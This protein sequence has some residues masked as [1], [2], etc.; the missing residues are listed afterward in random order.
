[1]EISQPIAVTGLPDT[2]PEDIG[3]IATIAGTTVVSGTIEANETVQAL[4]DRVAL[5]NADI[6]AKNI[7]VGGDYRGEGSVLNATRTVVDEGST[8]T[9][10]RAIVWADD[11]TVM[12]GTINAPGGFVEVSGKEQLIFRGE[13]DAET[14]LFDPRNITISNATSTTGIAMALMAMPDAKILDNDPLFAGMNV[15]ISV[16]D[17]QGLTQ[18]IELEATN[19]IIVADD[20]TFTSFSDKYIKWTADSDGDGSG[21]IQGGFKAIET[22]GRDIFLTGASLEKLDISTT[23]ISSIFEDSGDISVTSTVGDVTA[24]ELESKGIGFGDAGM[25]TVQAARDVIVNSSRELDSSSDGL[26]DAAPIKVMAG[27]GVT[28]LG[29]VEANSFVGAGHDITITAEGDINLA[30]EVMSFGRTNNGNITITSNNGAINANQ[31]VFIA[32]DIG[33][34]ALGFATAQ[35]ISFPSS[36]AAFSSNQ[37]AGDITFAAA[38]E[39]NIGESLIISDGRSSTAGGAITFQGNSGGSPN[40]NVETTYIR[41]ETEDNDADDITF[42]NLNNLTLDNVTLVGQAHR[43]STGLSPNIKIDVSGA[44]FF[45]NGTYIALQNRS[46]QVTG[47]IMLIADS[48][49]IQ[50]SILSA[51]TD[52]VGSTGTGGTI[53]INVSGDVIVSG[54]A[55]GFVYSGFPAAIASGTISPSRAGNIMINATNVT[56]SDDA[57]ISTLSAE[58]GAAG[59]VVIN[60]RGTITVNNDGAISADTISNQDGGSVALTAE[61]VVLTDNGVISASGVDGATGGDVRV[62]ANRING[63]GDSLIAALSVGTGNGGNVILVTPNLELTNSSSALVSSDPNSIDAQQII[64]TLNEIIAASNLTASTPVSPINPGSGGGDAGNLNVIG[65]QLFL[66]NQSQ[67]LAESSSGNGGNIHLTI[68]DYILLR[69]NSSISTTAGTAQAGGNGGNIN[70]NAPFIIGVPTENSDITANAFTGSGGNITINAVAI[71]GLGFRPFLTALSDITASS[72]LGVQGSVLL[73]LTGVD[74]NQGLTAL[75]R[76]PVNT[77]VAEGCQAIGRGAAVDFIAVGGG[78]ELSQSSA[79]NAEGITAQWLS[80]DLLAS[81]PAIPAPETS[82]SENGLVAVHIQNCNG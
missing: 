63:D 18:N 22:N 26:G 56:V 54:I 9:S 5:T 4:G 78:Y 44:V 3:A 42:I 80:L 10:E 75:P 41:A 19:D 43:R 53:D 82:L 46:R 47:N 14:I 23:P 57:A 24:G 20:I 27:S 45:L 16:A 71:Y 38:T 34:E 66:S 37:D 25:I 33:G 72:D 70:I 61:Y 67:L 39:I 36:L 49:T 30:Q 55:T 7:Q 11:L 31:A 79:I 17:L 21:S 60:A 64:D 28:L 6:K 62:T 73:N 59:D 50:N 51:S 77:E 68:D 74:L 69:Y 58:Q 1:S 65:D 48:L 2:L 35:G 40:V 32:G 29:G 8:L 81:A 76:E 52:S 13:I 12:E 15:T